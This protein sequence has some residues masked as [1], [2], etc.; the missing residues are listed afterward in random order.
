[1]ESDYD[2][3]EQKLEELDLNNFH[4]PVIQEAPEVDLIKFEKK[5]LEKNID[6][7]NDLI[8]QSFGKRYAGN[9]YG[10]LINA[11]IVDGADWD[12]EKCERLDCICKQGIIFKKFVGRIKKDGSA[13]AVYPGLLESA[14]RY[15][16]LY[17][18]K[19]GIKPEIFVED[20]FIPSDP[21][22]KFKNKK[23]LENGTK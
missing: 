8:K 22:K 20:G 21:Y 23:Q 15:R 1:M 4:V 5:N 19:Y 14:K 11:S 17:E 18:E 16:D 13:I 6:E 10:W 9:Y 2:F 12:F 7:I 3:Y